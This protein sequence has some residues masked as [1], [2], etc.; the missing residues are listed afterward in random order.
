MLKVVLELLVFAQCSYASLSKAPPSFQDASGKKLIFMDIE[1]AHY[2]IDYYFKAKSANSNSTI[3]FKTNEVGYP[4][5]DSVESPSDV[6][7]DGEKVN[8][9]LVSSPG[10]DTSYQMIQKEVP[11]GEHTLQLY[12]P[13]TRSVSVVA[14][15]VRSAF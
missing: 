1:T 15:G 7:L 3:T 14:N 9:L 11:A 4:L 10:E 5:F 13:L 6:I 12:V 2:H 8:T